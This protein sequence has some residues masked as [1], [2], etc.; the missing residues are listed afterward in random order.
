MKV[1]IRK[2]EES[3]VDDFVYDGVESHLNGAEEVRELIKFYGL[4]GDM[5]MAVVAGK[6]VACAGIIPMPNMVGNGVFYLNREARA[7]I[8]TILK[9]MKDKMEAI[10]FLRGYRVITTLCLADNDKANNLLNH[11][12]FKA[13]EKWVRYVKE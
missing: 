10:Q 11:L 7:Y 5:Y 6:M 1:D 9:E 12:G 8:K 13:Q 4:C 3:Y 2:F